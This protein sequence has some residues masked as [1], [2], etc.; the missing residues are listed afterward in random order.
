[1]LFFMEL[2]MECLFTE[3]IHF[4]RDPFVCWKKTGIFSPHKI[5][6][7]VQLYNTR[8]PKTYYK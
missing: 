4:I 7:G 3:Y 5:I 1:M 6:N 8:T 2:F